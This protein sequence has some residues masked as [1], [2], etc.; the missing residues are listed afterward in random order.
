MN[1]YTST[2]STPIKNENYC[3]FGATSFNRM[4]LGIMFYIDALNRTLLYCYAVTVMYVFVLNVIMLSI[5]MLKAIM[6]STITLCAIMLRVITLSVLY[7]CSLIS[8]KVSSF[9]VLLSS[10]CFI[11]LNAIMHNDTMLSFSLY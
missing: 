7:L 2:F 10:A 5:I 11:I 3:F 4:T 8:C 6:T 9:C 1:I